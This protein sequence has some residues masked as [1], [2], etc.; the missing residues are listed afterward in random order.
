MTQNDQAREMQRKRND[1]RAIET[2][3]K[4]VV[5]ICEDEYC[6]ASTFMSLA[7]SMVAEAHGEEEAL[8]FL[9]YLIDDTPHKTNTTH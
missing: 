8:K 2:A 6:A 5:S 3:V 9:R 4:C 7:L 1:E